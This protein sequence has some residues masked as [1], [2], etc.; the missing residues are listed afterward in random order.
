M[1]R[2]RASAAFILFSIAFSVNFSSAIWGFPVQLKPE[3]KEQML[4][5][6]REAAAA[7]LEDIQHYR[8]I[9]AKFD[10]SRQELRNLSGSMRRLL[11]D[12]ELH[13]VAAPRIGNLFIRAPDLDNLADNWPKVIPSFF[14]AAGAKI[15]NCDMRNIRVFP[16]DKEKEME[17]GDTDKYILIKL[18]RFMSQGVIC[19]NG[20][21]VN[22][23][24]ILTYIAYVASGIH[25]KKST[26]VLSE[27]DKIIS[28]VRSSAHLTKNALSLNIGMLNPPGI[29]A[30]H[31]FEFKPESVDVIL[32]ELLSI[33]N[34]IVKSNDVI[35]LETVI[36]KELGIR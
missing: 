1:E 29:D 17:R 34:F 20:N 4:K 13:H 22:R 30:E 31:P 5:A 28:L 24:N 11:I 27:A 32:W 26:Y 15:F 10:P 9:V 2:A 23:Q 36:K 18:E 35:K 33:V 16:Q 14:M 8:Q 6:S 3:Q 25:H 19:Y 12:R 7:F 21:W